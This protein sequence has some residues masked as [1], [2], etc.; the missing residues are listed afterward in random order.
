MIQKYLG[1]DMGLPVGG[2]LPAPNSRQAA[3][4]ARKVI[5]WAADPSSHEEPTVRELTP[6]ESDV[7]HF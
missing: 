3:E 6:V 2:E 4:V 5:R 7:A 1:V